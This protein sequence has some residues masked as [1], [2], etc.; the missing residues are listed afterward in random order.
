MI[1]DLIIVGG[2]P[3]GSTAA[4]I[5]AE[6]GAKVLLLEAEER[7]RYK[8]CAG[9]IPERN[10]DFSPIPNSVGERMISGGVLVTP[11]GGNMELNVADEKGY[12]MFRT[13]FDQ[14]L[15]DL[16]HDAGVEIIYE[17]RVKEQN[18]VFRNQ[19]LANYLGIKYG[20]ILIQISLVTG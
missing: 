20:N 1:Y 14:S 4:K 17:S 18:I 12:C 2:G 7:G 13:D 9:G 11:K 10:K 16:A 5:A 3:G 19:K 8:C 6:G 15:L